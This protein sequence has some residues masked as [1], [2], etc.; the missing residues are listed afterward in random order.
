MGQ[1]SLGFSPKTYQNSCC[2]KY[3]SKFEINYCSNNDL[4]HK[5]LIIRLLN[6]YI[7]RIQVLKNACNDDKKE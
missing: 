1:V 5:K 4:I 7:N 2:L 6:G 3:S